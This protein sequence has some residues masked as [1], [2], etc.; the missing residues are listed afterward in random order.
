MTM[1]KKVGSDSLTDVGLLWPILWKFPPFGFMKQ[2]DSVKG[3]QTESFHFRKLIL[4]R[5]GWLVMSPS[6]CLNESP[7][8]G[9]RH[10]EQNKKERGETLSRKW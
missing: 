5:A 6:I 3:G 9:G 10:F 8:K 2:N 7:W 1:K 4:N